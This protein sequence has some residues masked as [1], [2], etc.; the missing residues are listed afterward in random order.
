MQQKVVIVAR[1]LL[2]LVFVVF[3]LNFFLHFIPMP[4]H[5]GARRQGRVRLHG[6]AS[7]GYLMPLRVHLTEIVGGSALLAGRFVPL[8][9]ARILAP[10]IANIVAFHASSPPRGSCCPS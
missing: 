7:S 8:A 4:P 2:G 5:P 3:G 10:V 9:P 1:V 6:A